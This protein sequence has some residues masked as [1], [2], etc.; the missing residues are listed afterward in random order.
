MNIDLIDGALEH[1]K[2]RLSIDG[3][4]SRVVICGSWALYL[5]G[6]DIGRTPGDIDVRL[7][8]I[9]ILTAMSIEMFYEPEIDKL[10]PVD[11]IGF[12]YEELTI[13]NKKYFVQTVQNSVDTKKY[14]MD[15]LLKTRGEESKKYKKAQSDLMYLKEKY[16]IA[17][18]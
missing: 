15:A 17:P 3:H 13:N 14:L 18:K 2:S 5:H 4:K 7:L 6:I 12:E 11:D 8:D 9:D 10:Y 16:G 1:I